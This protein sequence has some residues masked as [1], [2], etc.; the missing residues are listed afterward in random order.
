MGL[1]IALGFSGQAFAYYDDVHYALTYY[2]ARQSGYT[3]EQSFRI[4]SACSSVDWDE[5]TE[6]VQSHGQVSLLADR[7]EGLVDFAEFGIRSIR[8][9]LGHAAGFKMEKFLVGE[10]TLKNMRE[11]ATNARFRFHAFRNELV[12]DDVVG[13]GVDAILAQGDVRKQLEFLFTSAPAVGN[14]GVF[15]HAF[16]DEEPHKGYGTTWG[17]NP[18]SP[19]IFKTHI[20]RGIS[21][22][23]TTDWVGSRTYG[24][25]DL[26]RTVNQRLIQFM[27]VASPHQIPR[28]YNM[29]EFDGLV[30]RLARINKPPEPIKTD[31]QRQIFIRYYARSKGVDI[32]KVTLS[33]VNH[34][35]L[36]KIAADMGIGLSMEDLQK[37]KDGPNVEDAIDAVIDEMD[38]RGLYEEIPAHHYPYDLD[39]NGHLANAEQ[40]D[41]W[42]LVG[43]L[44][45]VTRG[46]T[47][48]VTATVKQSVRDAQGKASYVPMIGLTPVSLRPGVPYTWSKMPIGDVFVEVKRKDGTAQMFKCKLTKQSNSYSAF[49]GQS[50]P[51]EVTGEKEKTDPVPATLANFNGKWHSMV[52][53]IGYKHDLTMS[54]SGDKVT[55]SW[56]HASGS[57]TLEGTV[58]A[59]T[60]TFKWK[61]GGDAGTGTF[62]MRGDGK[63]FT[64]EYS[65]DKKDG[66]KG[67]P[68]SG[69]RLD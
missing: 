34:E 45:F 14:V 62:R 32:D 61:A 38:E 46:S 65:S 8:T 26:C 56:T 22:G 69:H 50:Q 19:D 18:F 31:L 67:N 40:R 29:L 1:A 24:V 55:G 51:T 48:P 68:W 49:V 57:G 28:A 6:P 59:K 63:S 39:A 13:N 53:R 54:Q 35:E 15:L 36:A 5:H 21:V 2:I 37:H 12:H 25:K 43:D 20:D 33:L 17:H 4:A 64:G 3:P 42:V 41:N 30:D 47:D 58:K 7:G 10:L 11:T 9:V 27:K 16:Q 66:I 23:S 60:L 52:G 44:V